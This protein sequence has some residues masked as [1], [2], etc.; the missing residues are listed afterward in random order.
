MSLVQ[1]D[2]PGCVYVS[3]PCG[4]LWSEL[5]P[6]TL[7]ISVVCAVAEDHK[8]SVDW[9]TM[10]IL[11]PLLPQHWYLLSMLL[12]ATMLMPWSHLPPSTNECCWPRL[13]SEVMVVFVIHIIRAQNMLIS[14]VYIATRDYAE[15][16]CSVLPPE[17]VWKS[18]VIAATDWPTVKANE[19]S[20]V[21]LLIIANLKLGMRDVEDFYWQSPNHPS[22]KK[23]RK[24][25]E[26]N[27]WRE[28]LKVVIRIL[29][30]R[31]S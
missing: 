19:S 23:K 17:N 14:I 30:C 4:C 25:L 7:V 21:V 6:E 18:M 2:T 3:S 29:K 1:A 8:V 27:H 15:I 13:P 31:S 24:C 11:W 26:G 5:P 28:H 10:L 16:Q 20:I 9:R 22:P 12:S